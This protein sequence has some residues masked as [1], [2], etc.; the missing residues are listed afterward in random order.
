MPEGLA[1]IRAQES[2]EVEHSKNFPVNMRWCLFQVVRIREEPNCSNKSCIQ[3]KVVQREN[4]KWQIKI[5]VIILAPHETSS[6]LDR[7]GERT[8][9]CAT[10][11]EHQSTYLHYG[12]IIS[13]ISFSETGKPQ[14]YECIAH[15]RCY[16]PVSRTYCTI[17]TCSWPARNVILRILTYRI[18]SLSYEYSFGMLVPSGL[19]LK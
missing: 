16:S 4:C 15:A 17:H 8:W 12:E 1:A 10:S 18:L 7:R 9:R 5:R 14:K 3:G 11:R 6:G 2:S 13:D 19:G